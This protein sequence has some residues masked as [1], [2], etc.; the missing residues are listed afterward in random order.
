MQH[1]SIT[2]SAPFEEWTRLSDSYQAQLQQMAQG[3]HNA[4][5]QAKRLARE[6]QALNQA[7]RQNPFII[8]F[9]R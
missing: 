5:Q 7:M 3:D 9:L 2:A 6:L 4:R 8:P 1:T